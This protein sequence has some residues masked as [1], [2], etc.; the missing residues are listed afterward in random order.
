MARITGTTKTDI[1]LV[2]IEPQNSGAIQLEKVTGT[3]A[4]QQDGTYDFQL[5]VGIYDISLYDSKSLKRLQR[6]GVYISATDATLTLE[7]L[8]T[9]Q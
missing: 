9:R 2:S 1:V 7:G 5:P 6:C 8:L 4:I 3:Q